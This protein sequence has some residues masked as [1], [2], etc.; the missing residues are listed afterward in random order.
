MTWKEVSLILG[1]LVFWFA[2]N[3]WILPFFGIST[4]MSGACGLP[5]T[6]PA[7]QGTQQSE[8]PPELESETWDVQRQSPDR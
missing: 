5:S 1:F 3:R 7:V 4:C 2:L 8:Q 6:P